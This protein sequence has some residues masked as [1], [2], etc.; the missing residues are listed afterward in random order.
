MPTLCLLLC[1]EGLTQ[2]LLPIPASRGKHYPTF[3]ESEV[4]LVVVDGM[5]WNLV[6]NKRSDDTFN[7]TGKELKYFITHYYLMS[8]HWLMFE[9]LEDALFRVII[10]D[11]N[12][13]E[14]HYPKVNSVGINIEEIVILTKEGA[15]F[16]EFCLSMDLMKI[17]EN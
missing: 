5:K 4:E 16:E 1:D 13:V 7:L 10:M 6:T 15:G 9:Y 11:A 3:A 14:I 17:E 8:G 12:G 2:R